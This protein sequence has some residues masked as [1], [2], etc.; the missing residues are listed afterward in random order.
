MEALEMGASYKYRG[1]DVTRQDHP[2]RVYP[3]RN[4]RR[5]GGGSHAMHGD[6]SEECIY[7]EF[8]DGIGWD[9]HPDLLG[10]MVRPAAVPVYIDLNLCQSHT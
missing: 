6:T 3:R 4:V 1:S 9:I 8:P 7:G 5:L 2:V 10:E